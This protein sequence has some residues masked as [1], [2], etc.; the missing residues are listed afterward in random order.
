MNCDEK[1]KGELARKIW[2]SKDWSQMRDLLNDVSA[3]EVEELVQ[4]LPELANHHNW[5]VRADIVDLIGNLKLKKMIGLVRER[6]CDRNKYVRSWALIAFY[7]LS[8]KSGISRIKDF[9][10]DSQLYVR[11]TAMCLVYIENK[12]AGLLGEIEKIITRENCDYHLQY[13]V[14]HIF[15]EFIGLDKCPEIIEVFQKIVD[16]LP[17]SI[18]ISKDLKLYSEFI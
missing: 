9:L 11:L 10:E 12:D 16:V 18:E 13:L 14:F 8:G 4:V 2:E 7:K 5:V 3:K 17:D 6:L 1:S 15:D